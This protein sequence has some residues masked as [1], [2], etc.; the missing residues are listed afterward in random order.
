MC[1]LII[2]YSV[3]LSFLRVFGLVCLLVCWFACCLPARSS[4]GRLVGWSVRRFVGRWLVCLF[5][6]GT[7][8][9]FSIQ[10]VCIGPNCNCATKMSDAEIDGV[11]VPPEEQ[12]EGK[13]EGKSGSG[14]TEGKQNDDG[15]ANDGDGSDYGEEKEEDLEPGT[16]KVD[17]TRDIAA[18]APETPV[19]VRECNLS[20]RV[21]EQVIDFAR[22]AFEQSS[23]ATAIAKYVKTQL[24][25]EFEPTWHV[26][27]GR[28]FAMAVS[29]VS[30]G[31]MY[32][33]VGNIA[34]LVFKHAAE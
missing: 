22:T 23:V 7:E 16:L 9:F 17:P 1:S 12:K 14:E 11:D 4:V 10:G 8:I 33:Y 24:D 29:H 34:F 28:D 2:L 5:C 20:N 27:V 13:S 25:K 30:E 26:I 32:F 31:L 21:K 18:D 19:D 15:D 6:F 3:F